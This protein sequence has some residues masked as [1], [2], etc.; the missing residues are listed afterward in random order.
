MG[1]KKDKS[2]RLMEFEAAVRAN[3]QLASVLRSQAINADADRFAY[4]AQV[5]ERQVL[6]RQ[7][8]RTS[9][10]SSWFLD[11]ISGYG[12]RPLR[13][14]I[15]YALVVLGFAAAY[16]ALGGAN[17]GLWHVSPSRASLAPQSPCF[18]PQ[19]STGQRLLLV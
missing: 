19:P 13:S 17:G 8:R 6:W 10:L 11:L 14:F 16:F 2:T 12:Y 18:A 9:T 7:G 1:E 3:R 15:T 5:L 4:K